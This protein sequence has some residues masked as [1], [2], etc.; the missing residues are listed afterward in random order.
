MSPLTAAA[1]SRNRRR[2]PTS[3]APKVEEILIKVLT[4]VL[5]GAVEYKPVLVIVADQVV[6]YVPGLISFIDLKGLKLN[7]RSSLNQLLHLLSVYLCLFWVSLEPSFYTSQ[8]WH[9][10]SGSGLQAWCVLMA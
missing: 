4:L 9:N 8:A 7:N 10:G 2:T 3:D 1:C 5:E 6:R